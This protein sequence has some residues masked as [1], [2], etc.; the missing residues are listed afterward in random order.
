MLAQAAKGDLGAAWLLL[1]TRIFPYPFPS[2]RFLPAWHVAIV[3]RF[4]FILLK[5]NKSDRF[6][7]SGY[8]K[9]AVFTD[10]FNLHEPIFNSDDLKLILKTDLNLPVSNS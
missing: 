7:D 4:H 2:R 3:G 6:T 5:P 8:F 10:F 1:P 9:R